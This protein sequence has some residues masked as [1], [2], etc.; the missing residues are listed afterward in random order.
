MKCVFNALPISDDDFNHRDFGKAAGLSSS[1]L[2]HQKGF[3]LHL[4]E[5]YCINMGFAHFNEKAPPVA[6]LAAPLGI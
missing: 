4:F 6:A 5:R 2:L 1:G 3:S